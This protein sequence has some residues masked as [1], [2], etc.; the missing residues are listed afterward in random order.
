MWHVWGRGEVQRGFWLRGSEGK[1][2]LGRP[3]QTREDNIEMYLQKLR[4]EGMDWIDLA[5]D[6]DR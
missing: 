3:R 4:W 5:V 2:P 1:Q 6:R